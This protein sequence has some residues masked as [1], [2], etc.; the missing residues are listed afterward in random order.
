MLV[1]VVS[2]G[3]TT[4]GLWC[5]NMKMSGWCCGEWAAKK[6]QSEVSALNVRWDCREQNTHLSLCVFCLLQQHKQRIPPVFKTSLLLQLNQLHA[7]A[8][9]LW[10]IAVN[11]CR[12]LPC[13]R[14]EETGWRRK[15]IKRCSFTEKPVVAI[16]RWRRWQAADAFANIPIASLHLELTQD[17]SVKPCV[18][19]LRADRGDVLQ[20]VSPHFCRNVST[21]VIT[22]LP[23]LVTS[24]VHQVGSVIVVA[25]DTFWGFVVFIIFFGAR[26][27]ELL[28]SGAEQRE[29]IRS[30]QQRW[31]TDRRWHNNTV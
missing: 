23:V 31:D 20:A 12:D 18:K 14:A 25:E 3:L 11:V 10:V 9:R 2:V 24:P 8:P 27:S 17:V 22:N 26:V 5:C 28:P 4:V 13:D 21:L 1:S 19:E 7:S 30:A 6:P 16:F 29:R 15:K